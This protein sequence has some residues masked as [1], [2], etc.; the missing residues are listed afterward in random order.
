MIQ[1]SRQGSS[2]PQTGTLPDVITARRT[3]FRARDAGVARPA[4][5]IL[6]GVTHSRHAWPVRAAETNTATLSEVNINSRFGLRKSDI[7]SYQE[8]GFVKLTG[9]FNEATLAHYGPEMSLEVKQADDAP[10]QQDP[11]YQQAFT[12]V[13]AHFLPCQ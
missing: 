13:L 4:F 3:S 6:H 12:Q 1:C 11:A 2:G 10:L 9:V 5:R 7:E 8:H